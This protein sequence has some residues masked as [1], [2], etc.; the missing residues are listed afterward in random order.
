[1]VDA[2]GTA[3][4]WGHSL[5]RTVVGA[6]TS[7]ADIAVERVSIN[8]TIHACAIRDDGT[9]FC[10]THKDLTP[11]Q[12]GTSKWSHVS[13]GFGKYCGIADGGALYCWTPTSS[14][15]RVGT[16]TDWK[17]VDTVSD[18]SC[19]IKTSGALYCWGLTYQGAL[20]DGDT[21]HDPSKVVTSPERIAAGTTWKDITVATG[22]SC[23]VRTDGALFCWGAS[24]AIELMI[25]SSVPTQVGTDTDWAEAHLA[26][27]HACVKKT[28]GAMWC[29]GKDD[30]GQLGLDW[31]PAGF[32]FEP[33]QVGTDV[34]WLRLAIGEHFSCATKPDG[35][36]RCFGTDVLGQLG[37]K[38]FAHLSPVPVG[39]PGEWQD[40]SAYGTTACAV[41]KDG[42]LWCWGTGSLLEKASQVPVQ[43]DPATSWAS[44]KLGDWTAC[45]LRSDSSL[46]CFQNY[47]PSVASG[48][49]NVTA[50]AAGGYHQ[51]AIT[52]GTL[53]CWGSNGWGEIGVDPNTPTQ[54]P[55]K[56]GTDT[57][58]SVSAARL[59][60]CAIKS[61]GTNWCW[62][63]GYSGIAEIGTATT[64]TGLAP[65]TD[66]SI[67]RGLQGGALYEWGTASQPVLAGGISDWTK[68]SML[69]LHYCGIRADGSLS[70]KGSNQFGQI[71]VGTTI[72]A[73]TPVQV[74]AAKDWTAV[75]T[76]QDFTCAVRGAGDL[77]CWGQN[78]NGQMGDGTAWSITPRAV[79]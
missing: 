71:G 22:T 49:T 35:T 47:L 40:V 14:P 25:E 59:A 20:G 11:V 9:L 19:A 34:D 72:D 18:H 28:S 5:P 60:T 15:A 58:T 69:T 31:D 37:E 55:T 30:R 57:W 27:D 75:A 45:G 46:W 76:G 7:F 17:T 4:C 3:S 79:E 13:L 64:W 16:D 67:Y 39:A 62:G 56:V 73:N 38:A 65:I 42:T 10:F 70:C 74:G 26:Y 32:S 21:D 8:G 23:G 6:G 63:F 41:K 29:W 36:V 1:M 54:Q 66:G 61:D 53:Y 78:Q 12:V 51:C 43:R 33:K 50:Y 44:V 52:G 77:Y 24:G 48:L 2:A 68:I